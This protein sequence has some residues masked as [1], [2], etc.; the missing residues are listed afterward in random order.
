ME[1]LYQHT[2]KLYDSDNRDIFSADIPFYLER[3][4]NLEGLS[5]N[6]HVEQ[7]EL[8]F[9]LRKRVSIYGAWIIHQVCW[10]F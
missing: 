9:R 2:A 1:N 7:A 10:M 5:W 3:A 4:K 6:W 8:R